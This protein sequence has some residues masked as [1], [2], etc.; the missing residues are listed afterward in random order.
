V[1]I[2]RLVPFVALAALAFTSACSDN[3]SPDGAGRDAV[4]IEQVIRVV[5]DDLSHDPDVIPV[6]YVVGAEAAIPIDVQAPVAAA[7]LDEVDVRFA[8]ERA[9]ALDDSIEDAPVR[10]GGVLLVVGKVPQE[11]RQVDVVAE[12]YRTS[13]DV[14]NIVVSLRWRDP[15]WSVTSTSVVPP[16]TE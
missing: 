7:L 9:E 3:G 4:V 8:D 13:A 12:R 2:H 15:S 16:L 10:D 6:V 1:R 11:G 14:E 5:L